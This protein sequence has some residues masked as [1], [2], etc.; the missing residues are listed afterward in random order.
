MTIWEYFVSIDSVMQAVYYCYYKG[1]S[2]VIIT[3]FRLHSNFN[4]NYHS[5]HCAVKTKTTKQI[6]HAKASCILYVVCIVHHPSSYIIYHCMDLNKLSSVTYHKI[7]LNISFFCCNS[8]LNSNRISV[9]ILITCTFS[10]QHLRR[11][12][13]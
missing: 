2:M 12:R 6:F 11:F 5:V 1:V 7:K 3:N 13:A 4:N 8:L 10:I 9:W